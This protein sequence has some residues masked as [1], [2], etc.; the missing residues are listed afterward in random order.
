MNNFSR[1]QLIKKFDLY[2]FY[3]KLLSF[4]IIMFAKL[5]MYIRFCNLFC[6][7]LF[8]TEKK[9]IS[10]TLI[11]VPLKRKYVMINFINF[12]YKKTDTGHSK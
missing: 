3:I 12:S 11:N 9:E 7:H 4:K 2:L 6:I 8:C 1:P 10:V 5:N